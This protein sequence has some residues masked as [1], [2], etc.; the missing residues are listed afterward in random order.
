MSKDRRR[1]YGNDD[2]TE[3]QSIN[4]SVGAARSAGELGY[5]SF[6]RD[7]DGSIKS[8]MSPAGQRVA[9]VNGM[10][11]EEAATQRVRV[12]ATQATAA[13]SA[14]PARSSGPLQSNAEVALSRGRTVENYL[15]SRP[16]VQDRLNAAPRGGAPGPTNAGNGGAGTPV[17]PLDFFTP[18]AV[19]LAGK[20]EDARA[21]LLQANEAFPT[22]D[23]PL[24]NLHARATAAAAPG[25]SPAATAALRGTATVADQ[26]Q[27]SREAVAAA[28]QA[29]GAPIRPPDAAHGGYGK[30]G[31]VAVPFE[32]QPA[33]VRLAPQAITVPSATGGAPGQVVIGDP[34]Q[35]AS[36]IYVDGRSV[37]HGARDSNGRPTLVNQTTPS[38]VTRGQPPAPTATA[39]AGNVYDVAKFDGNFAGPTP[40]RAPAG[41]DFYTAPAG[42]P[43]M[44]RPLGPG[45]QAGL[46]ARK[47]LGATV[48]GAGNAL[49]RASASA[50]NAVSTGVN[51][52]RGFFGDT[53]PLPSVRDLGFDQP[54]EAS[55]GNFFAPQGKPGTATSNRAGAAPSSVSPSGTPVDRKNF[56]GTPDYRSERVAP[57]GLGANTS[58]GLTTGNLS[59]GNL[60]TG[61]LQ[62]A[63]LQTGSLQ[64]GSLGPGSGAPAKTPSVDPETLRKLK[65]ASA[66]AL[67][68]AALFRGF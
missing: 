16:T 18:S 56:I 42:P 26:Q 38:L 46:D 59:A 41:Q 27:L 13:P 33:S 35:A 12:G 4:A 24:A 34:T 58:P 3:P 30:I 67:P 5:H 14:T 17:H 11:P 66:G 23:H 40:P 19:P 44:A 6:E 53:S 45:L 36:G 63:G 25:M 28:N 10:S 57:S 22:D 47:A 52:V 20:P 32:Q 39:T 1:R 60:Q 15:A 7:F 48:A 9:F 55:A 68:L 51:A 29:S 50:G 31:Q 8:G 43:E 62:T 21:A 65:A 61:S 64:T 2:D 54:P 37:A 49:D